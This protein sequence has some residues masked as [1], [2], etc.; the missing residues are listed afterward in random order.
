MQ[1]RLPRRITIRD[2]AMRAEVS[3]STVSR[4]LN[5]YPFVDERTRE[6]VRR[7]AS[8][9]GYLPDE[10]ARSMRTGLSRAVGLVVDDIS[11]PLFSALAKGADEVLQPSSYSLVLANSQCDIEREAR[12]IAMLKQ[13]RVDALL[14][15]LVDEAV[16]SLR[17]LLS[18]FQATVVL[19]RDPRS[20]VCDAVWPD[21]AAGMRQALD[22]L[23]ELGHVRIGLV[24]G[25]ATQRGSRL[26]VKTFREHLHSRDATLVDEF[27]R[28]G[29]PTPEAG[30]LAAR[31]LLERARPPT[32][33]IAGGNQIFVGVVSATRDLGVSIPGELSIVTCDEVDASR[34]TEPPTDVIDR[35]VVGMGRAAAELALA[36]LDDPGAAP[37]RRIVRTFFVPRGSAARPGSRASRVERHGHGERARD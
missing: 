25:R 9:L 37:R 15:A 10:T 6:R 19:D 18:G 5:D 24:A 11:N 14:V 7:A 22:Y 8:D 36:R 4:V 26:R 13:R 33:I 16:P 32:A 34:L 23:I 17:D 2:V 27:V 35:D 30:Y 21:H 20:V 29:D 1:G 31:D 28:T 3:V 12:V